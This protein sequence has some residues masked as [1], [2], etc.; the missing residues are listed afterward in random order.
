MLS[1]EPLIKPYMFLLLSSVSL[2]KKYAEGL[3]LS[4]YPKC[5]NFQQN[6]IEGGEK[7]LS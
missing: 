6:D 2:P 1:V 7:G 3:G 4:N 5:K